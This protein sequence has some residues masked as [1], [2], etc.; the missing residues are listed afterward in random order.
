MPN[1]SSIYGRD[2]LNPEQRSLEN[3]SRAFIVDHATR[4]RWREREIMSIKG[5]A[6]STLHQIHCLYGMKGPPTTQVGDLIGHV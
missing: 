5:W 3:R 2:E 4:R 1:I 6:P